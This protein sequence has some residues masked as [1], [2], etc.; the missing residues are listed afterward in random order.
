MFCYAD[1]DKTRG[2]AIKEVKETKKEQGAA[3]RRNICQNEKSSFLH[4]QLN[5]KAINNLVSFLIVPFSLL[6]G[7]ILPQNQFISQLFYKARPVYTGELCGSL[8]KLSIGSP[9]ALAKASWVI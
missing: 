7:H 3:S 5:D 2:C 9:L 1:K 6:I 8:S 4:A